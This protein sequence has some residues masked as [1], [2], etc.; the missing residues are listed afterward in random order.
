MQNFYFAYETQI[1]NSL[2]VTERTNVNKQADRFFE[3][4]ALFSTNFEME[5]QEQA[6]EEEK[7]KKMM[8]EL[9][10]KKE[11]TAHNLAELRK[12]K[13]MEQSPLTC[14]SSQNSIFSL[15]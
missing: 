11:R 4:C 13:S 5:Q 3:E 8:E 1:T 15:I 2:S 14:V 12:R 10:K 6:E 9:A 7:L